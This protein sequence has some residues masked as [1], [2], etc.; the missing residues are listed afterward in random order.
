M[1][2]PFDDAPEDPHG[3]C[4][5]EIRRLEQ[6][7]DDLQ[8]E[9]YVNCVYCGHR[10]GPRETTPVSMADALKAHIETCQKHPMSRMRPALRESYRLMSYLVDHSGAK[11]I[12]SDAFVADLRAA[13]LAIHRATKP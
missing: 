5:A 9:M 2:N 12:M 6:M 4:D 8:S 7:V 1:N 13:L 11:Q 10:Y 3:E